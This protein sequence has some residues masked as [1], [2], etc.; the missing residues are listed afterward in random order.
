[1]VLKETSM[2]R[3]EALAYLRNSM[4]GIFQIPLLHSCRMKH[5]ERAL[6]RGTLVNKWVSQFKN[7][8]EKIISVSIE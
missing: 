7:E 4:R 5:P 3:R 8:P 2:M 1:V 6:R